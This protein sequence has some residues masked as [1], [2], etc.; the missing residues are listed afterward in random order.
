MTSK[1]PD[2]VDENV[3]A[4]YPWSYISFDLNEVRKKGQSGIK[5]PNTLQWFRGAATAV[6]NLA[7]EWTDPQEELD[8]SFSSY[9]QKTNNVLRIAICK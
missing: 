1:R 3:F 6:R 2:V 4:M 8:T 9:K 5:N 7:R